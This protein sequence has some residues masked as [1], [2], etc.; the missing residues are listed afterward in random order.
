MKELIKIIYS[1]HV[2]VKLQNMTWADLNTE[3]E[4][5]IATR[6][7]GK[8]GKFLSLDFMCKGRL[9]EHVVNATKHLTLKH[10]IITL[11][12]LLQVNQH[13]VYEVGIELCLHQA[14]VWDI[15]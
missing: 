11:L 4:T 12:L 10:L 9:K 5:Q 1:A 14:I 8:Q 2:A 6:G 3:K 13:G 15:N 7:K